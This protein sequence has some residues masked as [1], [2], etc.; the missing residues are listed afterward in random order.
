MQDNGGEKQKRG[1]KQKKCREKCRRWD[2][3]APVSAVA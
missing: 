3:H 1:R 2:T